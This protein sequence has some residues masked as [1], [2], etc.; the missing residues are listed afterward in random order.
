MTIYLEKHLLFSIMLYG[1][2]GGKVSTPMWVKANICN[3][4]AYIYIL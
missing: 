3:L 1:F 4:T 2:E